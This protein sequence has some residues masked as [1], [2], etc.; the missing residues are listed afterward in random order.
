MEKQKDL[1]TKNPSQRGTCLKQTEQAGVMELS[2]AE[3]ATLD[4][5][6]MESLFRGASV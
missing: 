6:F 1:R 5:V 2:M 4:Q 3:Q